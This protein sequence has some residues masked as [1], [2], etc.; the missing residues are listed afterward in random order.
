MEVQYKVAIQIMLFW[1][2]WDW[3]Q[4]LPT[5]APLTHLTIPKTL[6]WNPELPWAWFETTAL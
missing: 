6:L 5:S 2:K 3:G 4:E 1:I